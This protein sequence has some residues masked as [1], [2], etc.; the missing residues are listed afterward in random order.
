MPKLPPQTEEEL[1]NS[2][3]VSK[4]IV[5][6]SSADLPISKEGIWARKRA[7]R[8]GRCVAAPKGGIVKK[9]VAKKRVAKK[10]AAK[11][12]TGD[13]TPSVDSK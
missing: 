2:A 6:E 10:R 7:L 8:E 13:A 11:T 3:T 4:P 12:N 9:K 5:E 1:Y